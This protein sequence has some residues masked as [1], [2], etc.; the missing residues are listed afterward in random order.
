MVPGVW[1]LSYDTEN[2]R[3][4]QNM[5]FKKIFKLIE[6]FQILKTPDV[7]KKVPSYAVE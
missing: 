6:N 7:H 1:N 5:L 3:T 2:D 4:Q